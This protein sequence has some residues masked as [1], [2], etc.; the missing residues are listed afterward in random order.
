[1]ADKHLT[2]KWK[3]NYFSGERKDMKFLRGFTL[4]ALVPLWAGYAFALYSGDSNNLSNYSLL[5]LAFSLMNFNLLCGAEKIQN[6]ALNLIAKVD[7]ILFAVW[8]LV[9]IVQLLLK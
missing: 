4:L 3:G 1:M 5:I 6:K 8:A 9:T 7:G 2:D